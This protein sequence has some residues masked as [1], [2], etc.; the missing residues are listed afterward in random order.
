VAVRDRPSQAERLSPARPGADGTTVALD[1][2]PAG[3]QA[4]SALTRELA[5]RGAEHAGP[6]N[7]IGSSQHLALVL[8]DRILATPYVNWKE[9]P[10]GIEGAP[11]ISGL[12]T[13]EQA[14]LTAALLSAGPLPGALVQG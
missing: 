10:E 13:R 6:G 4:F 1:V 3:R 12:P 14:R 7:P 5:H 9:A 11:R 2:T 8:D